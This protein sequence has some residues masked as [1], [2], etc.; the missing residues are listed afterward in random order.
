SGLVWYKIIDSNGDALPDTLVV[1]WDNVGYYNQ[2]A[3]LLDTFQVAISNGTNPVLGANNVCFSYDAM[4]WST[5]DINGVG[6]FGGDNGPATVGINRGDGID[7]FQIGRF[8][9][10][11]NAYDGPFGLTDGVHFLDGRRFCFNTGATNVPPIPSNFPASG[12]VT[13]EAG[14]TLN[15]TVQLLSPEPGQ[16]TTVSFS[17]FQ[18]AVGHGLVITNNPGNVATINLHW[19]TGCND[20]GVYLLNFNA[21]DNFVPPGITNQNL[22]INV[23]Q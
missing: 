1:T 2:H 13:I 3:D 5:G 11:S 17:D 20:F 22:I 18:N 4:C 19:V 10:N 6:G 16:T 9:F 7:Y 15:L 12:I 23:T 14:Q 8:G 21:A